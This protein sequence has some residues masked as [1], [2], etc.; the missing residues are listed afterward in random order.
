MVE[1]TVKAADSASAMEE[2]EKRLGADAM[3]VSTNRV[4]GQIEIV[5]TNDDPSKYQKTPEPLV[6]DKNYRIKG[7]SDV[8]NAKLSVDDKP[9]KSDD[10]PLKNVTAESHRQI[11]ENAE[12]IK[13]EIDKLV[14]LSTRFNPEKDNDTSVH[15][16]F[17]MSGIKKSLIENIEN[18]DSSP[19]I[20]GASKI[21]A[22]SFIHGKCDHFESSSLYLVMGNAGA[23]KTLFS[24]KLKTLFETQTDAKS[25]TLFGKSNVKKSITEIKSWFAKNKSKIIEK[26]KIGIIELSNEENIDDFLLNFSK[27]KTD[28]KISI[29]N[30]IPVGNS[31]EYLVKNLP[32]RRLENEYLALTKLDLC[33]L[34]ILEIAAFVELNHK[35]MFFSG[36]PS[37][38]EGLYFA[39]VGQTVDHIVQTIENRMD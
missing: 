31:Y 3:I 20:E 15:E 12:N 17:Q 7:F 25:C 10:K 2:I 4:D 19:S 8:L 16:L 34:S 30:L 38:E 18:P 21:L 26:K 37:S 32:Q 39:K 28:I 23:G 29:L 1:I 24:K 5:A 14:E 36:V 33:D 11:A 6:L 13:G 35:C 9:L 27:L 22:K